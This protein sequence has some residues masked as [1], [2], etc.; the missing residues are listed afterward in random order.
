M[1]SRFSKS[2]WAFF[3]MNQTLLVLLF[4]A[5]I[6]H[7][8]EKGWTWEGWLAVGLAAF[9]MLAWPNAFRNGR[10]GQEERPRLSELPEGKTSTG[11]MSDDQSS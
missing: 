8:Q 9:G 11:E 5:T 2:D 4:M 3:A 1:K 6:I 10:V 7:V